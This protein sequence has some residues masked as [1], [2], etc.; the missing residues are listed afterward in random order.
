MKIL[1]TKSG[2]IIQF[3]FLMLAFSF[4]GFSQSQNKDNNNKGKPYRF[5]FSINLF[6]NIATEDALAVTKILIEKV[7]K[8]SNIEE[9]VEVEVCQS[10]QELV[11][12]VKKGF[13]F[14]LI[15]SVEYKVLNKIG[16]IKPVLVNETQGTFGLVYYLITNKNNKIKKIN[17]LKNGSIKILART[18]GQV[19]S[20]WL[21][22]I[23]RDNKLPSKEKF[24][25]NISFDY[26][27]TNVV[28]PVF[29]NK[30][31]AAIISKPSFEIMCELNPQILKQADII[32]ISDPML[33]GI[34]C[35][36]TRSKDKKREQ[37]LYNTLL[38]LTDDAS[39]KQLLE[40][41]NVDRIIPFKEEYWQNFLKLYK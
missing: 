6:H 10:E 28:L 18:T 35:F 3:A 7:K 9:A 29:F 2:Y 30:V 37:F 12:A 33:F 19:S 36:D 5:M 13:D 38:S 41:F 31:D 4:V 21:D 14:I 39:G 34:I 26:K 17:D 8:N 20:L 11:N 25:S 27:P 15:S 32:E 24:F 40:L 16:N 22:K 23:L 1:Y